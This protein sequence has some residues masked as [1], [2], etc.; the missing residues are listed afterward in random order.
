MSVIAVDKVDQI[1]D[2][3]AIE[4][5]ACLARFSLQ[6]NRERF[7]KLVRDAVRT[8]VANIK[9]ATANEQYAEVAELNRAVER[10]DYEKAGSLLRKLS[11][12]TRD[13]LNARGK[14]IKHPNDILQVWHHVGSVAEG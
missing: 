2:E 8:Y 4:T 14:K 1:F 13:A 3:A 7:G 11:N 12:E 10:R 9:K 6:A 5:L